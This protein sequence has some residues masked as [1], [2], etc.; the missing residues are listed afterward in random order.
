MNMPLPTCVTGRSLGDR[1]RPS[2]PLKFPRTAMRLPR[3]MP[4]V[5]A[6]TGSRHGTKPCQQ[7]PCEQFFEEGRKHRENNKQVRVKL[8]MPTDCTE[9]TAVTIRCQGGLVRF[10]RQLLHRMNG[11]R[12]RE[13]ELFA[14]GRFW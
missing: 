12:R 6:T 5:Q 1:I 10:L 4:N 14:I 2:R 9:A 8:L 13:A 11:L 7:Q 3:S